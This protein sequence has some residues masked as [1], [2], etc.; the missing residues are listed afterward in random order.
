MVTTL[1]LQFNLFESKRASERAREQNNKT[2]TYFMDAYIV[3]FSLTL[4]MTQNKNK[5]IKTEAKKIQ[6]K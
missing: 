5:N 1:F 4:Q 6:S 3:W 2:N